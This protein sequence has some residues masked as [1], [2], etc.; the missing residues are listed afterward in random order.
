MQPELHLIENRH[1]YRFLNTS[2]N[3]IIEK[4]AFKCTTGNNGDYLSQLHCTDYII[5]RFILCKSWILNNFD[6]RLIWKVLKMR[7]I[8]RPDPRYA[9]GRF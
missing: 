8:T 2:D 1:F 9:S 4:K 5:L 6:F 7:V 3:Q